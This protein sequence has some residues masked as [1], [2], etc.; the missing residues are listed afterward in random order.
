M[1]KGAETNV[2]A[3]QLEIQQA[4]VALYHSCLRVKEQKANESYGQRRKNFS[5]RKDL[6]V[7]GS[8]KLWQRGHRKTWNRHAESIVAV[9]DGS[10]TVIYWQVK[11]PKQHSSSK[12]HTIFSQPCGRR[13][14]MCNS[15]EPFRFR[16]SKIN[17]SIVPNQVNFAVIPNKPSKRCGHLFGINFGHET[18]PSV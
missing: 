12:R 2:P 18:A 7:R 15:Y 4:M 3:K 14:L 17:L 1:G 13:W 6:Q 16:P 5:P 11:E 9:T 8:V 10:S